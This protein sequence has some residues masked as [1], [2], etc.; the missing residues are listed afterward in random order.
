MN[1][2]DVL[3]VS[4]LFYAPRFDRKALDRVLRSIS[5][6]CRC[7]EGLLA[8]LAVTRRG[9][10]AKF[11]MVTRWCRVGSSSYSMPNAPLVPKLRVPCCGDISWVFRSPLTHRCHRLSSCFVGLSTCTHLTCGS[12]NVR[13]FDREES[14]FIRL[15]LHKKRFVHKRLASCCDTFVRGML[16]KS[17]CKLTF[18]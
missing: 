2:N 4:V 17:P 5:R 14:P 1:T 12:M 11:K 16:Q 10:L 3:K 13:T 8:W 6:H 18:G 7:G 9:S 15:S